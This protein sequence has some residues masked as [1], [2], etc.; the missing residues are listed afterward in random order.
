MTPDSHSTD[1]LL[2]ELV[3][4]SGKIVTSPRL[5]LAHL[6]AGWLTALTQP[7]H[8]ASQ[9]SEGWIAMAQSLI[10]QG[11]GEAL[12]SELEGV[13]RQAPTQ[14]QRKALIALCDGALVWTVASPGIQRQ[15]H[16]LQRYLG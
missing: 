6:Q 3:N 12:I 16:W 9:A 1:H 4:P 10:V 2:V 13:L 11:H 5:V 14:G 8:S 15:W 7:P